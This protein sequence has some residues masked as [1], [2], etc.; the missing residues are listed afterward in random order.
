MAINHICKNCKTNFSLSR[1]KCP[2]C[3]APIPRVGKMYRVRVQVNGKRITRTIPNSLE[4]A[5]EIEAKLKTELVSGDYYDRRKQ[6]KQDV[7]FEEFM[8]K[9]YL[10]YAGDNKASWKKEEM[11]FRLWINPVMGSKKLSEISQIDIEKLKK[12]MKDANKA[13]KTINYAIDVIR[14][15]FNMAIRWGYADKNP[16]IG[17]KRPRQDNR[18]VRFLTRTE[19]DAL[20]QEC[21]KRSRQLFKIVSLS[22]YTG[23]RFGEIANLK[24]QDVDL[25]N[26]II[27]I[28]DPK[29]ATNRTAYIIPQVEDIF[30]NRPQGTPDEIVFKDRKGNKREYV[31]KAFARAVKALGLNDGITD[32]RNKVVFHTLRHTFASWLAMQGTPIYTIKELMGHKT[33]AMTERYSHLAPDTKQDAVNKV[34]LMSD[35]DKVVSIAQAKR[36]E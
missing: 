24:W 17:V 30:R 32:K 31:S 7:R 2:K 13:P 10:P 35:A 34:F 26:K 28:K 3:G 20:L 11:L 12:T 21:K 14:M 18:R 19:A 9:K 27:Y 15:A 1:K 6:A 16:A 22:L 23:M 25:E 4:L 33:L 36:K 8:Y 29:N 5:K